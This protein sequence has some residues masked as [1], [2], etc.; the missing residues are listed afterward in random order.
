MTSKIVIDVFAN[1][2]AYGGEAFL[3]T[4]RFYR[5]RMSSGL[6]RMLACQD[7][8]IKLYLGF[9]AANR[10]IALGK[11]DV[12]RP[13]DANPVSFDA[14]RHYAYARQF[15]A[16]HAIPTERVRYIYDGRHEG[17]LMFREEAFDATDRRGK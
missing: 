6:V 4:D 5:L 8:A 3:V 17:W 2:D 13:T 11:P 1:K 15:F 14:R 9:D 12:V 16:K 10:R 7:S